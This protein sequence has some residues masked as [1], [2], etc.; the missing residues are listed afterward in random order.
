MDRKYSK[1]MLCALLQKIKA[2]KNSRIMKLLYIHDS[3]LYHKRSISIPSFRITGS[4]LAAGLAGSKDKSKH[5]KGRL[6]P[7]V[8]N[9]F[10]SKVVSWISLL[11][12]FLDQRWSVGSSCW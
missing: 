2:E 5:L 10:G 12:T 6:G 4:T 3:E 8:G 11:V 9:V 1:D 7:R